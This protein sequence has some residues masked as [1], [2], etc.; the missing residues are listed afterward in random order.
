MS[1]GVTYTWV[2]RQAGGPGGTCVL[3]HAF[4]HHTSECDVGRDDLR[5]QERRQGGVFLSPLCSGGQLV[6]EA[7]PLRDCFRQRAEIRT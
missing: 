2:E 7:E 3:G 4:W 5:S 1:L 6:Q